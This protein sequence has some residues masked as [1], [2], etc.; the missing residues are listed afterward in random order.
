M[1]IGKIKINGREHLLCFS[2]RV[3]RSCSERY[4]SI[5]KIPDALSKGTEAEIMDES[6]WLLAEMMTAGDRYAKLEGL[7]NEKPLSVEEL[8]DTCGMEDIA[9]MKTRIFETVSNGNERMVEVEADKGKNVE[10]AQLT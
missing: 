7:E 10:T 5:D 8:Y 1:R 9:N 4:G 3:V 6:F 2:A